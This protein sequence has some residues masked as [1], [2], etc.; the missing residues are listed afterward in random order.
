MEKLDT[1]RNGFDDCKVVGLAD[2]SSRIVLC[3]SADKK[4]PQ[5]KLDA[6]CTATAELFDGAGAMPFAKA[7]SRQEETQLTESIV[8]SDDQTLVF[9]RS[10]KDASEALFCV[11]D[12]RIVIDDFLN[13]A[14]SGIEN[15]AEAS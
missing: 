1:L 13:A 12:P 14:R 8:L 3:V 6:Y 10:S 15:L 4:P 9:I 7:I 2:I 11:C 5:E